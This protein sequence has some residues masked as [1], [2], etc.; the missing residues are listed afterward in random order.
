MWSGSTSGGSIPVSA[1]NST[2]S[3][4]APALLD[5]QQ[6]AVDIAADGLIRRVQ[7]IVALGGGFE[8]NRVAIAATP[9]SRHRDGPTILDLDRSL[10]T[11]RISPPP[12][13]APAAVPPERRPVSGHDKRPLRRRLFL[14]LALVLVVAALIYAVHA[15]FF[16]APE[17]ETDDA[18]VAGDIVAITAREA[19]TVLAI[20]AD[21]TQ[22]A[23]RGQPLID[24]DPA[25]ADVNLSS[26]AAELAR[27]VRATRSDVSQVD[28]AQAQVA[29][30]QAE[31]SRAQNDLSPPPRCRRRRRGVG[32]GG[33][34]RRRLGDHRAPRC[35]SRKAAS[36]R[37]ARPCRA[38]PSPTT[39]A[40]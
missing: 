13:P 21:N 37:H 17:Q 3:P 10:T 29:Q 38:S 25:T 16:A 31:L 2:S 39:R 15:L 9:R 32:R 14:I 5:A 8:P 40:C 36:R 35:A 12:P 7:L 6:G 27:A 30:A 18:Y 24:L 28:E 20:H 22:A 4:P 34:P 1:R 26:A 33:R 23:K 11:L 19:G